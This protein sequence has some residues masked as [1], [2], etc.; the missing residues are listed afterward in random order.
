MAVVVVMKKAS[1]WLVGSGGADGSGGGGGDG[2]GVRLKKGI[3]YK[4]KELI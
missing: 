3:K 1:R 4:E 2:E